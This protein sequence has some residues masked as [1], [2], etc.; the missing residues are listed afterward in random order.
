M[1]ESGTWIILTTIKG[2]LYL[3]SNLPFEESGTWII[4]TTI[5]GVM[6]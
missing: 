4:L 2:K 3:L 5:K 1:A 6:I